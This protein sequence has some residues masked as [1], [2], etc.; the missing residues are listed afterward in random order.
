[1][2]RLGKMNDAMEYIESNLAG[3]ISYDRIAQIAGCSAYHFQRVFSFITDIPLSEYIRRRRLSAAAFELQEGNRKVID[4]AYKYGYESPEAFSRAFKKL[5]GVMP[6]SAREKGVLLKA[7]PKITFSVS[8][9]GE[10]LLDYRIEEREAFTLCGLSTVVKGGM[11]PPKF[12]R[13]CH[14]SGM[15]RK[16][17]GDLGVG[18]LPKDAPATPGEPV[19]LYFALYDHADDAYSYMICH[20]APNGGAPTGYETLSVPALTWAVFPSPDDA[21]ADPAVQCKR[22]WSRVSEWFAASEYEHALGPE[23]EKGYNRGNMDFYYKVWI[24][25]VKKG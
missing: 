3:E 13:Q 11:T 15:L 12:I 24:P 6:A 20:D 1:M 8:V 16:M 25:I 17:Y 22:A 10:V 19:S 23:L 14:R 4:V 7:C 2:D 21:G 5:H 18:V 9:K